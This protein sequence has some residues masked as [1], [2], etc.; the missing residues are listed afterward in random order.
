MTDPPG[1][2]AFSR[3]M[4]ARGGAAA[5]LAAVLAGCGSK[6]LRI[7][8]RGGARAT[9]ADVENLN[10]LLAVEHYGVAAYTAGIPLLQPSQVKAAKQFLGQELAH[11]VE[12]SDLI[13]KAGGKAVKPQAR[14]DVGRPQSSGDVLALLMRAE[15]AQLDGYL[16]AIP[17]LSGGRLKS[18]ISAI[19]AN[20]A[21]HLAVVRSELGQPPV[22]AAFATG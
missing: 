4:L 6:P 11:V 19:Y 16:S 7:R 12:L 5:A 18:T 17:R 8:V 15:Q 22:P 14:Y 21:Q 2:D 13:K 1:E 9:P 10:R 3:R 20:D